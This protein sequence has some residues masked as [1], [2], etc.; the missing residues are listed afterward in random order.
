ML[1]VVPD[2]FHMFMN[3]HPKCELNFHP[4]CGLSVDFPILQRKSKGSEDF[5]LVPKATEG[6]RHCLSTNI[7][8]LSS[9]A[10]GIET[11]IF[12]WHIAF[13]HKLYISQ[14]SLEL[15]MTM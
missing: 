10:L 1:S 12:S 7:L 15:G 4:K 11:P 14:P 5:R 9:S 3:F 13:Y 6:V 2:T 8:S